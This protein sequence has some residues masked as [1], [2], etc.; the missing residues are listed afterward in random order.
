VFYFLVVTSVRNEQELRTILAGYVAIMALLMVHSL[1]EYSLGRAWFAQGIC[2]LR[3][4][5]RRSMPTTSPAW[6]SV[7]S[8]SC[9]CSGTSG[10]PGGGGSYF[11]A[12]SAWAAIASC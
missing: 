4:S 10:R 5:A 7:H 12:I 11:L 8:L 2:V 1:R 3:P 9:G 6:S